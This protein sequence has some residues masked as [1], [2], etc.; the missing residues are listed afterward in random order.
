MALSPALQAHAKKIHDATLLGAS[1]KTI[2][3]LIEETHGIIANERKQRTA[4]VK[5]MAVQINEGNYPIAVACLAAGFATIPQS[6]VLGAYLII[7]ELGAETM[8]GEGIRPY[9]VLGN[10]WCSAEDFDEM[11]E[12]IEN[13]MDGQFFQVRRK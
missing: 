10:G 2:E 9:L 3:R 12:C 8:E 11:Y 1:R 6:K 4:V 5:M 13:V 7:N